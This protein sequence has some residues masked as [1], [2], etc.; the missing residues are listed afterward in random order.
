VRAGRFP[1][2]VD[3]RQLELE[4]GALDETRATGGPAARGEESGE[5]HPLGTLFLMMIYLMVL[6]GMW[7]ALYFLLLGR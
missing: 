5:D 6:A 3:P 7:G 1:P 4:A 2:D